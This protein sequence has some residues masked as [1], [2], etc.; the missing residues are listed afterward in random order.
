MATT[1]RPSTAAPTK[2]PPDIGDTVRYLRRE[3]K[4]TEV[5]LADGTGASPRTVRRWLAPNPSQPQ[6]RYETLID[7]MRVIVETLSGSLTNKGIRQWLRA[8]NR[9][10]EGARPID[11]LREGR[12]DRVYEAAQAFAQG[13]Y[14]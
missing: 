11:E 7:D 8:R 2:A 13:Y 1:A 10:L 4:L 12:F 5:D 3:V 9:N 6:D 14:V